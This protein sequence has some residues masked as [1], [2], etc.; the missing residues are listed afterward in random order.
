MHGGKKAHFPAGDP[1]RGGRRLLHG[2]AKRLPAGAIYANRLTPDQRRTFDLAPVG[3][4]DSEIRLARTLL[5]EYLA[6]HGLDVVDG[7]V[8]RTSHGG[9]TISE[10][11]A[12]HVDNV[13]R[14]IDRIRKLEET[15]ARLLEAGG[16]GN[17]D[18]AE[19]HQAW[20]REQARQRG[21]GS[22]SGSGS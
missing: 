14:I 4:L 13:G 5:D 9:E 11:K 10:T 2:G 21:G 16:G 8:C 1:R 3:E 20:L 7:L 17:P 12:L 15:R 18:D 6:E 22:P 19:L